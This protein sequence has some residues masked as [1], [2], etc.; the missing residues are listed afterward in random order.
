MSDDQLIPLQ[1]FYDLPDVSR[2][3]G[4][5]S[6]STLY[7]LIEQRKLVRVN[8]GTKALITGESLAEY[9]NELMATPDSA[10]NQKRGRQKQRDTR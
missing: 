10:H 5:I 3:L 9:V 8:L 4:N 1:P 7:R 2:K 6:R